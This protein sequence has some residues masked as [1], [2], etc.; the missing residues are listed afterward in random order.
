MK[1]P[2][3]VWKESTVTIRLCVLLWATVDRE[4]ALHTYEDTVL[5]LLADHH[6]RQISR[7]RVQSNAAGDPSEVQIIEFI[8]EAAMNSYMHDPR[9]TALRAERD[10]AIAKTQV[11]TLVT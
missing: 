5:A 9:R 7:E 6:G 11:L 3:C 4:A 8:D 10:A 1:K 2:S